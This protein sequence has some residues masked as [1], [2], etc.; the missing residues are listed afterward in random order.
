MNNHKTVLLHISVFKKNTPISPRRCRYDFGS[1]GAGDNIYIH[2]SKLI[3][4]K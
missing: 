3:K 2:T 1:V 4:L